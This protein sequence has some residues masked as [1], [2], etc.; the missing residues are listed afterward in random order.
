MDELVSWTKMGDMETRRYA[1]TVKYSMKFN[2]DKPVTSAVLNLGEVKDC[3]RIKLNEKELGTLLGPSF[4]L[5]IDNLIKGENS[6]EVEVTNV[7]ANRI[8]DLDKRGIVWR[9]FYD[10][11]FVN[12]DYKPFDASVWEIRDAGLLGPVTI[13]EL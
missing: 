12:I 6:L 11:N 2:W 13:T 8:R 10:I 4:K 9:N 5:K 1:G 7:A 3:A